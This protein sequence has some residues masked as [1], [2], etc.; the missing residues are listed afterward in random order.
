[1]SGI[2]SVSFD[3]NS[4][5]DYDNIKSPGIKNYISK[6]Y[7]YTIRELDG[8]KYIP[9][10]WF[11]DQSFLNI[12][13]ADVDV[14]DLKYFTSLYSLE[15]NNT[16]ITSIDDLPAF[17]LYSINLSNNKLTNI[18]KLSEYKK[19]GNI[20]VSNNNIQDVGKLKDSAVHN[21]DISNNSNVSGYSEIKTL[22]ELNLSNNN[23]S[24]LENIDY[25]LISLNIS[26]N[27]LESMPII[28]S[29]YSLDIS[30][31]KIKDLN[32]IENITYLSNLNISGNSINNLSINKEG[33]MLEYSNV[34][35]DDVKTLNN[36][37][38][39][40]LELKND[41][42]KSLEGFVPGSNLKYIDLSNNAGLK[43]YG[44]L[45]IEQIKLINCG[46]EELEDFRDK[47][48]SLDIS[49]NNISNIEKLSSSKNLTTLIIN[50]NKSVISGNISGDK[51]RW[52]YFDNSK[53]G[54][55]SRFN[56]DNKVD[57]TISDLGSYFNINKTCD[58][59]RYIINNQKLD[60]E[61]LE[62]T[63][64]STKE[65][66]FSNMILEIDA[67]KEG[68]VIKIKDIPMIDS[69]SLIALYATINEDGA[70]I[71][72]DRR[73]IILEKEDIKKISFSA[74]VSRNDKIYYP[75]VIVNIK[76]KESLLDSIFNLFR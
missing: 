28:S 75:N 70:V 22:T 76:E 42:I 72:R 73:K 39:W 40:G 34:S 33:L 9:K 74:T 63:F 60:E 15:L 57:V 27:N 13:N 51:L 8:K 69:N 12:K 49:N 62:T 4:T 35:I 50:N 10:M 68:N 24:E 6:Y 32:G 61:F 11:R 54:K 38:V 67:Y 48:N 66:Y 20:N 29:L 2:S 7:N 3:E 55:D 58:K 53:I 14:S 18:D 47:V 36:L 23:I 41:S 19:L 56:F 71:S 31:N 37:N 21:L 25:D 44:K 46:I 30:D 52:L 1:M 64:D 26:N 43:G 45:N 65:I 59:C 16:N 5:I 17:D